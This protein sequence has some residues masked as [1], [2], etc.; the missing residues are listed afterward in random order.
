MRSFN[1]LGGASL[2]GF[3][4]LFG[5]GGGSGA[6][7]GTSPGG[8]GTGGLGPGT[9]G[10]G[11]GASSSGTGAGGMGTGGMGTSGMGTGGMGTGGIGEQVLT[12]NTGACDS[13]AIVPTDPGD[14]K[15]LATTRLTPP[16]YPFTITD[17]QYVLGTSAPECHTGLAHGVDLFVGTAVIP[18]PSPMVL[19]HFDNAA[20]ANTA[21]DR[22]VTLQVNPP[23]T[24]QSGEHLFIAVKFAGT[25]PSDLLCLGACGPPPMSYQDDRTYLGKPNAPPYQWVT[26]GSFGNSFK[27]NWKIDATGHPG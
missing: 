25:F 16:S 10:M 2:C 7:T 23:V 26:L 17:I 21:A 27:T 19:H 12:I 18:P 4:V 13:T 15:A 14:E 20:V 11:T 6:S 1:A 3:L 24:L 5:C 8:T 22:I 9:G